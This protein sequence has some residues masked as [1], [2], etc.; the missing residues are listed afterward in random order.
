MALLY[1]SMCPDLATTW[2]RVPHCKRNLM[3]SSLL[4]LFAVLIS[5]GVEECFVQSFRSSMPILRPRPTPLHPISIASRERMFVF[6]TRDSSSISIDINNN[7]I[8]SDGELSAPKKK[9]KFS[10]LMSGEQ[11]KS[12]QLPDDLFNSDIVSN[13]Q[14]A[15]WSFQWRENGRIESLTK[16]APNSNN[17]PSIYTCSLPDDDF[18][19]FSK[20]NTIVSQPELHNKREI[21]YLPSLLTPSQV[22][23]LLKVIQCNIQSQS[24]S[25]HRNTKCLVAVEDGER[26]YDFNK[27]LCIT[28]ILEPMIQNQ[29]LPA[30]RSILEEPN[31]VVADSLVRWYI[32]DNESAAGNKSI[33]SQTEALPP[34]YDITSFA[35]MIAPLN[36]EECE[37]G[38]YVQY[39]AGHDTRCTLDFKDKL[40][41]RTNEEVCNVSQ[42]ES[43]GN[44][45]KRGDAILHRYDV[46]HG[47]QLQGGTRYSLVLWMAQDCDAMKTM[48]VPWVSKDAAERKS[49]HA[50]FLHGCNLKDGLYGTKNDILEAK[51]C[52]EWASKRGHALSQYNLAMLL[53]TLGF[54]E[55]ADGS[56]KEIWNNRIVSLLEESANRGLDLAQHALGIT[57]KVGYYGVERDLAKARQL[58]LDAAKQG[59]VRSIETLAHMNLSA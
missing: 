4:P 56:K 44:G 53:L 23:S 14:S 9:S 38:L 12:T 16:D 30:A 47:V 59:Y 39:G 31:L 19:S 33:V 57:Y 42:R 58:F 40:A 13:E 46:M 20:A 8:T 50:A 18:E 52:W 37:G 1:V 24:S 54:E 41:T 7:Q 51:L 21:H 27:D 25:V 55:E 35:T 10:Q 45:M 2:Q 32:A 15:K 34:H 11:I 26:Q 36:P 22:E 3:H 43:E 28:S 5:I 6:A 17:P 29:I 49:V 48:T